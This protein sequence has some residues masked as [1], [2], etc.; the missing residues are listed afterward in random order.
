[1][2]LPFDT[3]RMIGATITLATVLFLMSGAPGFRYRRQLRLASVAIYC[4]LL[5]GVGIW[6]L[7]WLLGMAR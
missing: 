6:V 4:L 1:M 2:T 5:A 7:L 3:Q